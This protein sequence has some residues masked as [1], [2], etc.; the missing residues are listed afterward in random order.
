[1]TANKVEPPEAAPVGE[2]SDVLHLRHTIDSLEKED[3]WLKAE[4]AR[5]IRD[6]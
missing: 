1:M 6:K 3:A 2:P 4:L 5:I